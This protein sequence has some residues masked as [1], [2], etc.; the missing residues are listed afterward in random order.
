MPQ[1]PLHLRP[2]S[3][4][5]PTELDE[6]DAPPAELWM[7]GA[8]ERWRSGPRLAIVGS[9]APTPYGEAQA[10][11]FA[12]ELAERGVAIVSG[13]A[14]GID[15]CAHRAALEAGGLTI[16]VLGSGV[17][18]PWP[19]GE[20]T[21]RIRREGIL[22]S[23]YPPGQ[24]PR[25]H[26]F[27]LRNRLISGLCAGVLVVE[28][29]RASGSLWTARWAADQGRAVF[30]LPGRVDHP[31]ARGCHRLLREGAAL[32]ESPAELAAELG[33]AAAPLG[34][35]MGGAGE[36]PPVL[37]A[38]R[39]ET[40][41]VE[42]L[43]L[44]LVR[45][46][47]EVLVELVRLELA[48]A[49]LRAPGGL[50][51]RTEAIEHRAPRLPGGAGPRRRDAA[52]GSAA[53]GSSPGDTLADGG[54]QMLEDQHDHG[55]GGAGDDE[56]EVATG[57]APQGGSVLGL[58]IEGPQ[59]DDRQREREEQQEVGEEPGHD[60]GSVSRVGAAGGSDPAAAAL[61]RRSATP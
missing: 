50:W 45:P 54:E 25:R 3:P 56:D 47:G 5:W 58:G 43:A 12:A 10:A 60:V 14:R 13:L 2:G 16:A 19:E 24:P 22:L 42:E 27:P 8:L 9:R 26:H 59:D 34:D 48:G 32:V 41:R 1:D 31:M 4:T 37:A 35:P 7:G 36:E 46:L 20:L 49:V 44:R 55:H 18:R 51:R 53:R 29:A 30:A 52:A 6:I 57:D 11:R 38:L 21:E 28:A 33:W 61:Q 40:L 15:A 23:E 17:D 39:G